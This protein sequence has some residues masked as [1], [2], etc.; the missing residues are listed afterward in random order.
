MMEIGMKTRSPVGTA[1]MK[2]LQTT[3]WVWVRTEVTMKVAE[4]F[5]HRSWPRPVAPWWRSQYVWPC[6]F[7]KSNNLH[8]RQWTETLC[9]TKCLSKVIVDDILNASVL[10]DCP[11]PDKFILS[12]KALDHDVADSMQ[13][14]TPSMS[15]S[16]TRAINLLAVVSDLCQGPTSSFGVN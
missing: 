14:N 16:K 2:M 5:S 12:L 9:G 4:V 15:G 3:E 13:N 1:I 10:K 6:S 11:V 7:S 8:S